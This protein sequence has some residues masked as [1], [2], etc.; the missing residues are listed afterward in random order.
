[1]PL[2]RSNDLRTL[3]SNTND[4]ALHDLLGSGRALIPPTPL[5]HNFLSVNSSKHTACTLSPTTLTSDTMA[6][7][8]PIA[9][10]PQQQYHH[11]NHQY[12][13]AE[14]S[15]FHTVPSKPQ[16]PSILKRRSRYSKQT[17]YAPYPLKPITFRMNNSHAS[18]P[19]YPSSGAGKRIKIVLH[20]NEAPP[21]S[22]SPPPSPTSEKTVKHIE[23]TVSPTPGVS[24][25][26]K[27]QVMRIPSRKDYPEDMKK[28]MWSS[29]SE[30][31]TNAKRNSLEYT[32]E[33]WNWRTVLEEQD[34]Y[35]HEKT[36]TLY[37]PAHFV[38]Q[39]RIMEA[40]RKAEAA[41]AA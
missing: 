15:A 31:A 2:S 17:R 24:F 21:S 1:M 26:G 36:G 13:R 11:Y 34:M 30:I 3:S 22:F 27:V 6:I 12:Y 19:L 37:H 20:G 10:A 28:A 18:E 14:R 8:K 16:L 33:G 9:V 7:N 35:M 39:K 25:F 40:K 4:L 38:H 5:A 32:Y 29:T 23:R 41:Q